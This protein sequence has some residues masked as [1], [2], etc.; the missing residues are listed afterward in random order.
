MEMKFER[1]GKGFLLRSWR[2]SRK[3]GL[4]KTQ[5]ERGLWRYVARADTAH[6][7]H[8]VNG[9]PDGGVSPPL[10]LTVHHVHF[11]PQQF[12]SSTGSF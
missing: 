5:Q 1:L 12:S 4:W 9:N 10:A 11:G 2:H 6:S 8:M 7:V 3:G